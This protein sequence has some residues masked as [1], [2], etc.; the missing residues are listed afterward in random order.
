M[1]GNRVRVHPQPV[2]ECRIG[3]VAP[4]RPVLQ[5]GISPKRPFPKGRDLM[6]IVLFQPRPA[7]LASTGGQACIIAHIV[8]LDTIER[9]L[10]H[11]PQQVLLMH[12][13]EAGIIMT[14]NLQLIIILIAPAPIP[15]IDL[16]EIIKI[17]PFILRIGSRHR[18]V[19]QQYMMT[20]GLLQL[21]YPLFASWSL[22]MVTGIM[23]HEPYIVFM[24]LLTDIGKIT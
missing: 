4:L 16:A 6:T 14:K 1:I 12:V 5:T 22:H 3:I 2:P 18:I 24:Q 19:E 23:L 15:D 7:I 11:K 20:L 21:P 13:E 8:N 17:M 9:H 10:F